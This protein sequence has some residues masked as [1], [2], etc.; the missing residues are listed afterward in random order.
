MGGEPDESPSSPRRRLSSSEQNQRE[1]VGRIVPGR[2][3]DRPPSKYSQKPSAGLSPEGTQPLAG[4]RRPPDANGDGP[5]PG[6]VAAGWKL[7]L[8]ATPAGVV[9]IG[10]G[11]PAVFDR[12]LMAASP[13]GTKTPKLR[14]TLT[15]RGRSLHS[16]PR[17]MLPDAF[18]VENHSPP[19]KARC[20]L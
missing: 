12:R 7:G 20:P 9:G 13:P 18:G 11:I 8:D 5:D 15:T 1:A 2:G 6:G 3:H 19:A 14:E 17:A 16:Q 10:T 4:G